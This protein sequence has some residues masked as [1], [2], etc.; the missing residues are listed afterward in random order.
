MEMIKLLEKYSKV[1]WLFVFLI[2]IAIFYMSSR[3]FKAGAAATNLY[4]I[5]YHF[6]AFFFLAL[7]LVPAIVKGKKK[8]LIFI[9]IIIAVMYGL[10][11]EI[12]QFFV[13]GRACMFSDFLT[14][15]AGILLASFF[16]VVSLRL[17]K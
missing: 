12:H 10:S 15:S 5:L 11:D 4:A 1:S 14:D 9:A 13:P 3:T 7:F 16:Y 6:F 2:A 8:N 17:R